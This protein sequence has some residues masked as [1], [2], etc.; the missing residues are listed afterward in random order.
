M[1]LLLVHLS[2]IHI[3]SNLDPILKK[4][5]AI[6]K[7]L[8]E[9]VAKA[10]LIVIVISGDIAYSGN[11][12]EYQAAKSFLEGIRKYIKSEARCDV[13]FLICP[14]NHDCDFNTNNES[15][16]NNIIGVQSGGSVDESV[17]KSCTRI[18]DEFFKFRDG[19]ETWKSPSTDR[20][21][22]TA[23]AV[24][25]GKTILFDSLNVAWVSNL[26]E[27][28][29]LFFPV[30]RYKHE[31]LTQTADIRFIAFHH[32]FNWFS[33]PTYRPFR[34]L[35]R[36]VGSV[37]ISGHEHEGNVGQLEDTESG[38]S[39]YIEG[40]VLQESS[41]D[42]AGTGFFI[43]DVDLD[44]MTF[45]HIG[46]DY[47]GDYYRPQANSRTWTMPESKSG[48]LAPSTEFR[49]LLDDAGAISHPETASP[50][51]LQDIYVY[52]DLCKVHERAK[53]R[54]FLDAKLLKDP[55]NT[56][57]GVV[58]QC[59]ERTGGTSLLYQLFLAYLDQGFAPILIRGSDI[60]RSNNGHIDGLADC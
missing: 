23:S 2:D 12:K 27:D 15:R 8:N 36:R 9:R 54:E 41:G 55:K 11:R 14:G 18:Q 43:L 47:A 22:R 58:L 24:V 48:R 17:I 10:K 44:A 6:A 29:N 34:K 5:E 40:R 32:P 26:K 13:E 39:V 49:R 53:A 50:I 38:Q 45:T 51:S 30:E 20:L 52:P 57:E 28:K 25:S 4:G 1:S 21:W 56:R 42:L 33:N 46:F 37:L 31:V 59:D 7:A 19:L 16:K 3:R 35:L 60:K